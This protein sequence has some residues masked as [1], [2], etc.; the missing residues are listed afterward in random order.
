MLNSSEKAQVPTELGAGGDGGN[1]GPLW[2]RGGGDSRLLSLPSQVT[3]KT[4]ALAGKGFAFSNMPSKAEAE[5][6]C[7]GGT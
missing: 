1:E 7:F 5:R 2:E 3:G 6:D 4:S